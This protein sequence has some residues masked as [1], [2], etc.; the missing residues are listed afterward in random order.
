M[1]VMLLDIF[2]ID[3]IHVKYIYF[4]RFPFCVFSIP[5]LDTVYQLLNIDQNVNL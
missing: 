5:K 2:Y 3:F 1:I 4:D